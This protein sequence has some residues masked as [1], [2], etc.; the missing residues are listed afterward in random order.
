[1]NSSVREK[2]GIYGNPMIQILLQI[3]CAYLSTENLRNESPWEKEISS[4][5]KNQ[6]EDQ[7][8]SL[9]VN[10]FTSSTKNPDSNLYSHII[11]HP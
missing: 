1:M 11:D 9:G 7:N 3:N 10:I 8:N 6:R 2:K 4:P 5:S